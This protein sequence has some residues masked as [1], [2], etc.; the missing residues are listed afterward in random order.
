MIK[1]ILIVVLYWLIIEMLLIT[2]IDT[3]L[4]LSI[5]LALFIV[6]TIYIFI[7]GTIDWLKN[8]RW[9]MLIISLINFYPLGFCLLFFMQCTAMSYTLG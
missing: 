5:Y 8:N 9:Q 7:V 2:F 1:K 6:M 4:I 3:Y